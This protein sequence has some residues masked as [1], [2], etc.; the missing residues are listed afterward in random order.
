MAEGIV[1]AS[2]PVLE[3][4]RD[5]CLRFPEAVEAGG[6]GNPSFKVRGKIF[7]MQHGHEGRPSCWV[8]ALEG[9]QALLVG[10]DPE[11]FFAPP[12]VGHHGW[13]G[14]RLDGTPDWEELTDLVDESY[15]LTAPKRLVARLES[16]GSPTRP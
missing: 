11:R 6:V 5:A 8:K 7:A 10:H 1:H 15:R 9:V 16:E 4:L 12:Y 13:V 3:R 2:A 14:I